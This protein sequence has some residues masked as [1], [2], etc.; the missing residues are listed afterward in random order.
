MLLARG[1]WLFTRSHSKKAIVFSPR[2]P[3]M[4]VT[5]L[6][7]TKLTKLSGVI[8]RD[9]GKEKCD[10]VTFT[11]E[12]EAPSIIFQQLLAKGINTSVSIVEHARLD[13][14]S[15]GLDE[16]VRASVHY[17]NTEEEVDRFCEILS[18]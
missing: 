8:V 16:M 10:I 5:N 13:M 15:R 3:N 9:L 18:Q 17:Y 12:G 4:S 11:K 7:R 1:I 6:L 2:K 14:G